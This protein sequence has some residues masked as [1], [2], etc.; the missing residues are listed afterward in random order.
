MGNFAKKK[1][2]RSKSFI[3]HVT[4]IPHK[5]NECLQFV[6]GLHKFDHLNWSIYCIFIQ[7]V[8]DRSRKKKQPYSRFHSDKYLFCCSLKKS[9]F[10]CS[11]VLSNRSD[12][13]E[14]NRKKKCCCLMDGDDLFTKLNSSGNAEYDQL[15]FLFTV[16]DKMS[17]ARTWFIK[18]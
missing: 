4:D 18:I 16:Q 13:G 2:K 9:L 3:S 7:P 1:K 5:P 12:T 8:Q 11:L 14:M 15:S 10:L 17:L 6:D